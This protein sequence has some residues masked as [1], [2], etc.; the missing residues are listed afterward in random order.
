MNRKTYNAIG[1]IPIIGKVIQSKVNFFAFT[2][3]QFLEEYLNKDE[4]RFLREWVKKNPDK[5]V[6]PSL[7][8]ELISK[9]K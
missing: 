1:Y 5:I 2:C 3:S 6:S 9:A 4:Y 7:A 8:K